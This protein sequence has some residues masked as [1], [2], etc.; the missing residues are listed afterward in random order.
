MAPIGR[1]LEGLDTSANSVAFSADEGYLAGGGY[2]GDIVIW[3]PATGKPSGSR[4]AGH[5]SP[6]NALQFCADGARLTSA[7]TEVIAWN[8]SSRR[9]IGSPSKLPENAQVAISPDCGVVALGENSGRV[10]FLNVMTGELRQ[11]PQNEHGNRIFALAF[12]PD[13][14]LL[15]SAGN[16]RKIVIWNVESATPAGKALLKHA[17]PVSGLQF[18][19]DG[20]TLASLDSDGTMILWDVDARE[21][22]GRPLRRDEQYAAQSAVAISADAALAATS[23]K[24]GL[25]YLWDPATWRGLGRPLRGHPGN[26]NA[27]V[28]SP[29]GA[30]V[31]SAGLG[32]AVV[33][34]DLRTDSWIAAAQRMANRTLS[35]QERLLYLPPR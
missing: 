8:L 4:L 25:L 14:R 26:V 35:D 29:R 24:E 31:A 13:G 3:E 27:I 11:P 10:R 15:A 18:T 21:P 12:S 1:A 16:D 17:A 5:R 34:W 6:V 32:G 7:A 20:R 33:L 28:V 19:A 9:P 30:W 22:R 2:S 23:G